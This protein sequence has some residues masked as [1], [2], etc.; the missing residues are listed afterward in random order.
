MIFFPVGPSVKSMSQL[1]QYSLNDYNFIGYSVVPSTWD[2]C[3]TGS[4]FV[5]PYQPNADFAD[6]CVYS[7]MEL[8]PLIYGPSLSDYMARGNVASSVIYFPTFALPVLVVRTFSFD[9]FTY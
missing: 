8:L 7:T 9:Y 6:L 5:S 2:I 4:F 1:C 3:G